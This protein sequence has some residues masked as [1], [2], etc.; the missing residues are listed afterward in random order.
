MLHWLYVYGF[1]H[2]QTGRTEWLLLPRV[3]VKW[4]NAALAE[5]ARC[6]GA[7][8]SHRVVLVL[9]Q[10]GWH[11]SEKVVV[12]E[13]IDLL[14]LPPYSPELQPAERLWSLVD[15]PLANRSF[16][17]LDDLEE[18]LVQRCQTL[19]TMT[20]QVQGRTQFYWWVAP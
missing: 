15:E 14:F 3:K 1:V 5:F 18:V 6:V 4:F 10:A 20:R 8:A 11:R 9:D 12:P 13:G 7:S 19:S 16:D 17:T 2:P